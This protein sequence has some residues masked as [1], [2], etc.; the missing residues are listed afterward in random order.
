MFN[1]I[2]FEIHAVC[3]IMWEYFV[4]PDRP[5]MTVW[6]MGITCWTPRATNRHSNYVISVWIRKTN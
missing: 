6:C 5:Q 3:E 1:D 4:E 2:F